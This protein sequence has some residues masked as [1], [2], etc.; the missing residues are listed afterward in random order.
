MKKKVLEG[1]VIRN[2]NDK[3]VTVNVQRKFMDKKY[4]KYIKR[5]KKYSVH[6]EENKCDIGDIV[7][8]IECKP[9]SKTKRFELF[10]EKTLTKKK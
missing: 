6:D 9:K 3:T 10:T 7:K 1:T 8:I 4:K 2:L 5:D